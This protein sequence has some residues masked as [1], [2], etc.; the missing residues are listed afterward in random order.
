MNK[1]MNKFLMAG[2][3]FIPKLHLKQP[4]FTYSACGP[5][6]RNKERIGKFMQT[7]NTDFTYRNELDKAC[8]QHDM[9]YGKSKD[10]TKRA[11][12]DKV[13]KDKLFK[14][15]KY[16][17]YQKGLPLLVYKFFDENC[18]GNG[19][20][21]EPYYQLAN[22]LHRQVIR[23]FKRRKVDSSFRDNIWGIYLADMQSHRK[24]NRGI[25][26]LLCAID[27]SSKYG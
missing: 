27:L 21:A 7:A 4:V 22:E 18:S 1:I 2:D 10:L 26:Y 25:K 19:L 8:F 24:Y 5:F 11:Q 12:W 14:I 16:Y 17:G 6:S 23:K 3:K 20:A 13:L 15:S 9:A